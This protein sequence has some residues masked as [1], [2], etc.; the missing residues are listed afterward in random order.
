MRPG[1]PQ[2]ILRLDDGWVDLR[3]GR[4]H[5]GEQEVALTTTQLHLLRYLAQRPSEEL[6]DAELRREVWGHQGRLP[7]RG[8]VPSTVRRL[9]QLLEPDPS[10][11]RYILTVHGVG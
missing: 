11:P 2:D 9:R 6:S 7:G 5:R 1:T 8:P 3:S 10:E 4:L